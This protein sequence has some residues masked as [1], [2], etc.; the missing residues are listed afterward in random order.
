M[1]FNE[2]WEFAS[3]AFNNIYHG[4]YRGIFNDTLVINT[5]DGS[6]VID[7]EYYPPRRAR[8]SPGVNSPVGYTFSW[9]EWILLTFIA[10][11][12]IGAKLSLNL[13]GFALYLVWRL[14]RWIFR[15][16]FV[17]G[18]L[19]FGARLCMTVFQDEPPVWTFPACAVFALWAVFIA[20]S[21]VDYPER[22]NVS[23]WPKWPRAIARASRSWY[24]SPVFW[25][26]VGA[27]I[28][29]WAQNRGITEPLFEEPLIDESFVELFNRWYPD[30]KINV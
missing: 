2:Q 22:W 29:I 27:Y 20:V 18:S 6:A 3:T 14:V 9:L 28:I 26:I 12:E 15:P 8:S 1:L 17:C 30:Y 4:N 23:S 7:G 16:L 25:N 11:A 24:R 21:Y 10:L 19:V 13:V 5:N